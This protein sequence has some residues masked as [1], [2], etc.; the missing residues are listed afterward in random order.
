MLYVDAAFFVPLIIPAEA[1]FAQ[2]DSS[3]GASPCRWGA[4]LCPH[5]LHFLVTFS[6]NGVF[7][8][9]TFHRILTT[10]SLH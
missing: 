10:C 2:P 4:A 3:V 5:C 8:L 6:V 1:A 7:R 9:V